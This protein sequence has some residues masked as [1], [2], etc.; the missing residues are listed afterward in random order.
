MSNRARLRPVDETAW[1]RFS[2][3]IAKAE[4]LGRDLSFD[5]IPDALGQLERLRSPLLA[6]LTLSISKSAATEEDRLLSVETAAELLDM[7]PDT[8][9]RKAREFPFTVLLPVRQVRFS[10]LGIQPYIRGRQGRP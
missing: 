8:L 9:Y 7:S 10:A 5:E 3:L 6:R 4:A 1:S 2:T